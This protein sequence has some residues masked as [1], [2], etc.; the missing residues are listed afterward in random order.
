[1]ECPPHLWPRYYLSA[2]NALLR[3]MRLV[4]AYYYSSLALLSFVLMLYPGDEKSGSGQGLLHE[5]P[6]RHSRPDLVRLASAL[7]PRLFVPKTW[8]FWYL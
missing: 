3:C 1:M 2:A 5:T 6:G 4:L 7:T 8:F